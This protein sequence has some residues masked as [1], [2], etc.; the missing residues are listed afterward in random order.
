MKTRPDPI[1]PRPIHNALPPPLWYALAVISMLETA[2]IRNANI[3]RAIPRDFSHTIMTAPSAR[4]TEITICN[5][6]KGYCAGNDLERAYK[7]KEA[8]TETALCGT[9]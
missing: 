3:I 2:P 8:Q 4:R 7:A 1:K 6:S 9:N 5:I